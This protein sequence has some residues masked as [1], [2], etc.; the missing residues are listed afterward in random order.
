MQCYQHLAIRLKVY[1]DLKAIQAKV[2]YDELV[3]SDLISDFSIESITEF[4]ALSNQ[5][6]QKLLNDALACMNL[7][8]KIAA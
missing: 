8:A 2:P 3:L 1:S 7:A 6:Y 4:N 5:T